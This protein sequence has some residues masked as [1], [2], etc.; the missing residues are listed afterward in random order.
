MPSDRGVGCEGN[1][2]GVLCAMV[3]VGGA[4]V[5]RGA[6]EVDSPAT[7]RAGGGGGV[8]PVDGERRRPAACGSEKA[9]VGSASSS[10]AVTNRPP[11]DNT[12]GASGSAAAPQPTS[13]D[14]PRERAGHE[15][16]DGE[17]RRAVRGGPAESAEPRR[18]VPKSGF[19][20]GRGT[21]V[22]VSAEALEKA[23]RLLA[24]KGE[25]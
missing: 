22:H 7:T 14:K 8:D 2:S 18:P 19:V 9:A 24:G 17:K 3:Q 20:T 11:D 1:G 12:P 21:P 4:E 6:V 10:V 5:P 15:S 25:G 16:S 23:E 13:E